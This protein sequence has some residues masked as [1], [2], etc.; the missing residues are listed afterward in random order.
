MPDKTVSLQCVLLTYLEQGH[1]YTQELQHVSL[2]WVDEAGTVI[3]E[4]SQHQIK[5]QSSCKITLTA[6]LQRSEKKKCRCQAIVD[7][8]IQTS[9]ELTVGA[10]GLKTDPNH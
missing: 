1:C 4:D 9:L 2:M 10:S 6:S 7:E 8:Q 3:Q 5:H